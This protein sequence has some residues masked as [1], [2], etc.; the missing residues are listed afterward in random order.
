MDILVW[1]TTWQNK[2]L[3]ID[4]G[5]WDCVD[6]LTEAFKYYPL[7][8]SNDIAQE[9]GKCDGFEGTKYAEGLLPN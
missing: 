2:D 3:S 4:K 7:R 8:A 6:R 9:K 5:A 1:H